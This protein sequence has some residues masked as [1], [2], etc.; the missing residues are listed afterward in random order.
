[1]ATDTPNIELDDDLTF[2][3]VPAAN[4][5]SVPRRSSLFGISNSSSAKCNHK[6]LAFRIVFIIWI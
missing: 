5:V 1:M 4:R 3:M 2:N 6:K